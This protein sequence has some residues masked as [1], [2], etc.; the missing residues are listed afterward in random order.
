MKFIITLC[1]KHVTL[2]STV[3]ALGV[4]LPILLPGTTIP[5]TIRIALISLPTVNSGLLFLGLTLVGKTLQYTIVP[6][7]FA[8]PIR[9]V[10]ATIIIII[11]ILDFFRIKGVLG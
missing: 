2:P 1:T 7:K 4:M 6:T 10:S 11:D 8:I 5:I 3:L 9:T